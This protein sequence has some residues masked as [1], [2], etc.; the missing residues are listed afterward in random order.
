[1]INAFVQFVWHQLHLVNSCFI[2]RPRDKRDSS[3][4]W[5]IEASEVYLHSH[6]GSG[7]FGTVFKGKWH[8]RNTLQMAHAVRWHTSASSCHTYRFCCRWCSSEDFK[9]HRPYTR[10][11]PG[12]QKWSGSP[13]VRHLFFFWPS[14]VFSCFNTVEFL[15]NHLHF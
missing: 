13:Q 6:I 11:V 10:A 4:Y 14:K 8:G 2:Q 15:L 12:F 7:S 1:M 5:E 3:Y 9:G